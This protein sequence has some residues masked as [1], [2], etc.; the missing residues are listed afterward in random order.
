V[1]DTDRSLTPIEAERLGQWMDSLNLFGSGQRIE[2]RF[3]SGGSQNEIF[4]MGA[5]LRE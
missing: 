5:A 4:E 2:S 1:S 3:I